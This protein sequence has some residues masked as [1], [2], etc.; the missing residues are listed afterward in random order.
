MAHEFEH[1]QCGQ[2][3]AKVPVLEAQA[4]VRAT[5]RLIWLCCACWRL[6]G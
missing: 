3:G 5:Q 1:V 2:C 4:I 6:Y